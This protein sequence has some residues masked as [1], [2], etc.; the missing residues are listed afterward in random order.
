LYFYKNPLF[1]TNFCKTSNNFSKFWCGDSAFNFV[2]K[3]FLFHFFQTNSDISN[4]FA[5]SNTC[6]HL[7]FPCLVKKYLL[8]PKPIKK[9]YK[10]QIIFCSYCLNDT[11]N[12]DF[13]LNILKTSFMMI[14]EQVN[15]YV[16]LLIKFLTKIDVPHHL[17][18][19][20]MC[21]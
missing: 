14:I 21:N 17:Y 3:T 5:L 4:T 19:T 7:A 15:T 2:V 18:F 20:S 1:W 8:W 10:H 6:Y 13:K 9:K 11:L 16:L 12:I